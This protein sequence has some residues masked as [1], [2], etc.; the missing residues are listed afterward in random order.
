[1]SYRQNGK[2]ETRPIELLNCD[3]TD[4]LK[5]SD[6]QL[7]AEEKLLYGIIFSAYV[8]IISTSVKNSLDAIAW[9][10]SSSYEP[11][12]LN[13]ICDHLPL[14]SV[15][16]RREA[17]KIAHKMKAYNKCAR[18]ANGERR[19]IVKYDLK[20][21]SEVKKSSNVFN[22]TFRASSFDQKRK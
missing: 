19:R 5:D 20:N 16:L 11:F 15:S 18:L 22:A 7:L 17:R 6:R 21:R 1:M 10:E 9:F 4:I 13:Y 8:D 14:N 12:S 2:W 3:I